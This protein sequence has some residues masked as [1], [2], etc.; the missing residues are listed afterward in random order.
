M[1]KYF[2]FLLLLPGLSQPLLG[3]EGAAPKFNPETVL[4]SHFT[5]TRPQNWQWVKTEQREGGVITEVIFSAGDAGSETQD[6]VMAYFS[7]FKPDSQLTTPGATA[8]RWKSWFETVDKSSPKPKSVTIGTNTVTWI[9]YTGTY[10]G[11]VEPGKT[12]RLRPGFAVFG[13]LIEDEAGGIIARVVGP[14]AAAEKNKASFK[15]M[16]EQALKPE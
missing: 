10:K 7:H 16:I 8:R 15:K 5:F 4:L 2:P 1:F 3:Q 9:E 13:A 6:Q 14:S 12:P 11:N